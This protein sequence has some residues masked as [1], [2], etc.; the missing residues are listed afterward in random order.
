LD[1]PWWFYNTIGTKVP[2]YN[3]TGTLWFRYYAAEEFLSF[4]LD[5]PNF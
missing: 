3:A 1:T 4:G 5:E 2:K